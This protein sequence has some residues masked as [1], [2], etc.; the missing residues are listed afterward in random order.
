MKEGTTTGAISEAGLSMQ[1]F[2]QTSELATARPSYE[3]GVRLVK[4]FL[5]IGSPERRQAVL[6][7]ATDMARVDEGERTQ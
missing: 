4:A 1:R 5:G 6:R 7:I 2:P 3:D